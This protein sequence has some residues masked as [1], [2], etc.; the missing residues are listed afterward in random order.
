[1]SN[2]SSLWPIFIF[3]I[4][5][6][7]FLLAIM[8]LIIKRRAEQWRDILNTSNIDVFFYAVWEIVN[9]EQGKNEG[10]PIVNMDLREVFAF[11]RKSRNLEDLCEASS[12][13]EINQEVCYKRLHY[14]YIPNVKKRFRAMPIIWTIMTPLIIIYLFT[15]LVGYPSTLP[16]I[17]PVCVAVGA[18]NGYLIFRL[19]KRE[20]DLVE[21]VDKKAILY[22]EEA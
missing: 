10:N 15:R 13:P 11:K 9:P 16:Y 3:A 14:F 4:L 20:L 7:G 18:A 17:I 22:L 19:H 2:G 1:M 8:L 21:E 12:L 5:A 6:F